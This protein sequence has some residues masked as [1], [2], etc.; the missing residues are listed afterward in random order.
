M[1][2]RELSGI[3]ASCTLRTVSGLYILYR[4]ETCFQGLLNL[5]D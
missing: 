3:R 1:G 2:E 5:V 4:V